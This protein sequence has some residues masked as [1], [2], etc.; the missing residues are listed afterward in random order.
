MNVEV[1]HSVYRKS[2]GPPLLRGRRTLIV[3]GTFGLFLLFEL[4]YSAPTQALE[5]LSFSHFKSRAAPALRPVSQPL[6]HPNMLAS[7]TPQGQWPLSMEGSKLADH[8]I[9]A[10]MRE[11]KRK[12]DKKLNS[13]STTLRQAKAVY[14]KKYGRQPPRG[15]DTWHDKVSS[16]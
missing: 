13:Q 4:F 5:R 6:R 12:W 11:A 16:T 3:I 1:S 7:H 8:P 9:P 10:L 14:V 15:F 2:S